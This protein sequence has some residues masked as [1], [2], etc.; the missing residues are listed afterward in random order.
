MAD[1]VTVLCPHWGLGTFQSSRHLASE[2]RLPRGIC[3]HLLMPWNAR[4]SLETGERIEDLLAFCIRCVPPAPAAPTYARIM[5]NGLVWRG[6]GKKRKRRCMQASP[7]RHSP[8][9]ASTTIPSPGIGE[10]QPIPHRAAPAL[11]SPFTKDNEKTHTSTP[12]RSKSKSRGSCKGR[13]ALVQSWL[14]VQ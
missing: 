1:S 13:H 4:A 8:V 11:L 3:L 2:M 10:D 12:A 9:R 14:S 7:S 5:L 6:E